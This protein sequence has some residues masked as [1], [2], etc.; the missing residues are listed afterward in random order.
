MK[1]RYRIRELKINCKK[2]L[3][4]SSLDE[5]I[6]DCGSRDPEKAIIPKSIGITETES[7]LDPVDLKIEKEIED[8]AQES[9]E[10]L[11]AQISCDESENPAI[12]ERIETDQNDSQTHLIPDDPKMTTAVTSKGVFGLET[13][14]VSTTESG[15]QT[16]DIQIK[17]YTDDGEN[18]K[19]FSG[20]HFER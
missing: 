1:K 6:E 7:K 20:P 18:T 16:S 4:I 11:S 19:E 9:C 15:A 14:Q 2:L 3:P 13:S 17:G 8:P 10:S 12:E 5:E